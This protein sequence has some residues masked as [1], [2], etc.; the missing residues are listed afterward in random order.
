[1]ALFYK[2]IGYMFKHITRLS[3]CQSDGLNHLICNQKRII[4]WY[5]CQNADLNRKKISFMR[6]CILDKGLQ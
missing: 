3:D 1:M 4:I 6:D 2:I 5:Y